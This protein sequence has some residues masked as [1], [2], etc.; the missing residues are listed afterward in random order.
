MPRS[1]EVNHRVARLAVLKRYHPH[2]SQQVEDADRELRV[3]LLAEHIT[4]AVDAAPPL[5]SEQRNRLAEL[6]RPV[7]AKGATAE[8]PG[9]G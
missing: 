4:R 1:D 2:D 3:Q 8:G 9:G 5:T 6:L 7:R